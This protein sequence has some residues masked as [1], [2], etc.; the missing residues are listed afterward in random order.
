[1][2][3]TYQHQ[4]P[5]EKQ[6]PTGFSGG[7]AETSY[8]AN[9]R[10][11]SSAPQEPTQWSPSPGSTQ[12][13][14]AGPGWDSSP[15]YYGHQSYAFSFA[16]PPFGGPRFVPPFGFDPSLPP[17]PFGCPPSGHM[18][19]PAPVNAYN[20]TA[21]F[22]QPPL[23]DFRSFPGQNRD[24]DYGDFCERGAPALYSASGQDFNQRSGTET[25][26]EDVVQ[27]KQDAEWLRRFLQR[28]DSV[29]KT[30][31]QQQQPDHSRVPA[32]RD[33]LYGAARLVTALEKSCETLKQNVENDP[34]WTDSY[35]TALN[36]KRELQD[37]L[38]LLCDG[39]SLKQLKVKVTRLSQ[40]KARR[41]RARKRLQMEEKRRQEELSEKEAAIDKWR[42]KKIHEVEEKKRVRA[43]VIALYHSTVL[44]QVVD[45]QKYCITSQLQCVLRHNEGEILTI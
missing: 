36:A 10:P 35:L 3:T 18:M 11:S 23:G 33:A 9:R 4:A 13:D 32:L 5:S 15:A 20:I 22:P 26:S 43:Y 14:Q 42:M 27:K 25:Q 24:R 21:P 17:P 2:D 31:T 39:E 19:P 38:K 28:R 40:R 44:S 16:P 37:K 41:Q 7:Y 1:M 29:S 6:R 8:S 12:S 30:P 45:M 34:V